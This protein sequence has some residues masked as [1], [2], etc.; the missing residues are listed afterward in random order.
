MRRTR[1]RAALLAFS[2]PLPENRKV[3]GSR[4]TATSRRKP[5][6]RRTSYA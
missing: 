4:F 5:G 2:L 6:E 1:R 3:P